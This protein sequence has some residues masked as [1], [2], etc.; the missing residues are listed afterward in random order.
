M[1]VK[2]VDIDFDSKEV[3][4]FGKGRKERI[5]YLNARAVV[6]IQKYLEKRKGNSEYLFCKQR[7][8]YSKL[9]TRTIEKEINKIGEK[10]GVSVSP[11]NIRH[12]TATDAI[13]KGMP[14]EQVQRLLGHE[15]I[16]TTLIYAKVSQKNVKNGHEKYIV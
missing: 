14:I 6:A 1:N 2:I 9:T 4:L 8:P 10:A 3:L 15:S 12:T 7:A 11:H 13:G 16:S 5:S